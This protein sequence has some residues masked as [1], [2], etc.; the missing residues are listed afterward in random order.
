M[1]TSPPGP[2]GRR[3]LLLAGAG[4]GA[5]L[6]R[7]ARAQG[8]YPDRP[9]RVVVS[10]GA[11]G[12]VDTLARIVMPLLGQRLGQPI[13]V[14]NRP[15]AGGTIGAGAVA[16]SQPDGYTLLD[17]GSG[18]VINAILMPQLPY[19]IRQ[20][21]RPVAR[22]ATIPNVILLGPSVRARTLPELL[23]FA[24]ANPGE[25]DC[26]STGV[27]SAQHLGL[28]LLNRMAGVRINHVPYRDAPASQ[29]DLRA[30]RIAMTMATATSA[31]PLNGQDGMRVIAHGGEQPIVALPD[32]PA[33]SATVPGF[34]SQEWQGVFAPA[35]TPAAIVE[36][37]NAELRAVLAEEAVV[38]RF[39]ALGARGGTETPAEFKAFIAAEIERIGA[40]VREARIAL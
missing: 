5:G 4:L 13:V 35:A 38:R 37:L 11:G 17:D 31:I 9:V 3:A 32:V 22:V 14:E 33:I 1:E 27:G 24:R 18:F 19:D 16:R 40:L 25:L 26:S 7:A 21:F 20:D 23:E 34:L 39:T 15:G 29:N 28:E 10:Y 6:S 12:A 30:G 36:R 2:F 8:G